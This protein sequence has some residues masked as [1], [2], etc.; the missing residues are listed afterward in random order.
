[1]FV[2]LRHGQSDPRVVLFD[3]PKLGKGG[4]IMET[5]RRAQAEFVAFVDADAATPPAE[6]L[7]LAAA[8]SSFCLL[9]DAES[10]LLSRQNVRERLRFLP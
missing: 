3:Y 9:S 1:M 10:A 7:R 8:S 6:L 2:V 5:F 4:V